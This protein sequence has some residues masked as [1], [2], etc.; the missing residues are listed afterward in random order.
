VQFS[1]THFLAPLSRSMFSPPKVFAPKVSGTQSAAANDN[2]EQDIIETH[3]H[4]S[5]GTHVQESHV[6]WD[7]RKDPVEGA[8]S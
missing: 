3:N 4:R 8:S 1:H 2:R 6:S 7:S 5:L